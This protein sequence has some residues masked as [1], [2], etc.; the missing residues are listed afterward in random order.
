MFPLRRSIRA[1]LADDK[2]LLQECEDTRAVLSCFLP[3]E[4]QPLT[5]DEMAD[6]MGVSKSESSKRVTNAISAG[7]VKRI[8]TGREVAITPYWMEE[9]VQ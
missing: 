8:R 6:R 1:A 4:R 2:P 5:N 7:Y 3:G 9:S